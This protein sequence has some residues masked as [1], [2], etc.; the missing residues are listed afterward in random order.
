MTNNWSRQ[1]IVTVTICVF[2]GLLSFSV[3]GNGLFKSLEQLRSTSNELSK[4]NNK[5]KA[6]E[7]V[8][9]E[10]RMIESYL[11]K[12]MSLSDRIAT[13]EAIYQAHKSYGVKP[14]IILTFIEVE[15]AFEVKAVSKAGAKGLMQVLPIAELDVKQ[16]GLI[17]IGPP[18]DGLFDPYYNVMV[19]TAYIRRL[20]DYFSKSYKDES[21]WI[22]L[23]VSYNEGMTAGDK[24]TISQLLSNKYFED[25]DSKVRR[26]VN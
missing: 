25:I 1:K 7:A 26:R 8:A 2:V 22:K 15:S 13:V 18:E 23:V 5:L 4:A 3:I 10:R 14:E 6:I 24:K 17:K 9:S 11:P 16:A 12:K 20:Y 21:L 19:G